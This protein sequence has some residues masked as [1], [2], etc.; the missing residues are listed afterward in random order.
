VDIHGNG[1]DS[2]MNFDRLIKLDFLILQLLGPPLSQKYVNDRNPGVAVVIDT[3]RL[4]KG[5]HAFTNRL[6]CLKNVKFDWLRGIS[7]DKVRMAQKKMFFSY[8]T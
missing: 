5:K 1:I 4:N 3:S 6:Q 8:L 7:K 2:L